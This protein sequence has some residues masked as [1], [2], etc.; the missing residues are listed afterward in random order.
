MD[1]STR[2]I[3]FVIAGA[4]VIVALLRYMPEVGGWV[5]LAVVLGMLFLAERAGIFSA[6]GG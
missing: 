5:L 6:I 1:A 2:Q 4:V 3:A